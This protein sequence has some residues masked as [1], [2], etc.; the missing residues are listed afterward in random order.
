MVEK[1][2][3]KE[4]NQEITMTDCCID[5]FKYQPSSS[6]LIII[7]QIAYE[8]APLFL[9]M[10]QIFQT[11]SLVITIDYHNKNET[12]NTIIPTTFR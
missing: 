4:V 10:V 3:N 6:L 7:T 11:V 12:I 8:W 1:C 2:Q 9:K 5:Y